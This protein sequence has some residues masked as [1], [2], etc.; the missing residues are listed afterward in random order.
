[1]AKKFRL[2]LLDAKM[3]VEISRPGLW[4]QAVAGCEIQLAQTVLEDS[5]FFD[6]DQ[7]EGHDSDLAPY[8][9]AKSIS[10]FD[11]QRM[12]PDARAVAWFSSRFRPAVLRTA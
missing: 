7:G 1:M 12:R 8:V 6:V 10:L 11:A 3:V 5:Q 2:L 9:A 4:D